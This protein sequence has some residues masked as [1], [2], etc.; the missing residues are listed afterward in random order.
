[1][2]R[3]SYI[4]TIHESAI[5]KWCYFFYS[6][7]LAEAKKKARTQAALSGRGRCHIDIIEN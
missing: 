4:A 3:R 7:N 1:M 6:R 5:E 2:K